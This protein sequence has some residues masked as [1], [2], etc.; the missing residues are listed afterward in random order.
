VQENFDFS[1]SFFIPNAEGKSVPLRESRNV[2]FHPEKILRSS[3]ERTDDTLDEYG[4][5]EMW[6]LLR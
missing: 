3:C 6:L 1:N 5:A 4:L 2:E